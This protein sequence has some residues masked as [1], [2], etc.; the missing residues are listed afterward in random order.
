[1]PRWFVPVGAATL[2]AVALALQRFLPNRAWSQIRVQPARA[3]ITP[4]LL[5]PEA[6]SVQAFP[7]PVSAEVLRA[8]LTLRQ[9]AFRASKASMHGMS[10]LWTKINNDRMFNL[11]AMLAYNLLMSIVPILA[12]FL[13]FFGLFLSGLA[14]GSEQQFISQMGAAIPGGRDLLDT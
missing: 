3:R 2:V 1:M 4:S 9:R 11:A 10:A 5:S 6:Q 8:H 12:M 7:S 13:S 14:P